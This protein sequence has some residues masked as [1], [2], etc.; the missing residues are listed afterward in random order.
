MTRD[1]FPTQREARRSPGPALVL[2][3]PERVRLPTGLVA[4]EVDNIEQT[5]DG[6]RGRIPPLPNRSGR[7]GAGRDLLGARPETCPDC[8]GV[9][10]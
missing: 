4:L 5:E 3:H 10:A 6:R 2:S 9:T 8:S 1:F 7:R